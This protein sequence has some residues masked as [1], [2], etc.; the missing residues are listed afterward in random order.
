MRRTKKKGFV[1]QKKN[2]GG[3]N[4]QPS[5]VWRVQTQNKFTTLDGGDG[6]T[7][8]TAPSKESSSNSVKKGEK[9]STK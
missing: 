2:R 7:D 1:E 9:Q 4:R 6:D 8:D 5:K 3:W